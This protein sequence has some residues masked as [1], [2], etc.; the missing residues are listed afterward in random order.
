MNTIGSAGLY[1]GPSTEF[2]LKGDARFPTLLAASDT[3]GYV[4][5]TFFKTQRKVLDTKSYVFVEERK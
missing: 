2:Y 1:S 5:I 4:N 3:E